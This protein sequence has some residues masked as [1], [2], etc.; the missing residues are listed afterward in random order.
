MK[1]LKRIIAGALAILTTFAFAGCD[2]S[3]SSSD[4][5]SSV[6]EE[7]VKVVSTDDIGDIPDG[8]ET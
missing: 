6:K 5:Q 7:T 1:N 3:G 2:K 4:S 8:A